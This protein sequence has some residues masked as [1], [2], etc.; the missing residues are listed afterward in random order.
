MTPDPRP[1]DVDAPAREVLPPEAPPSGAL[2]PGAVPPGA[3]AVG[4]AGQPLDAGALRHPLGAAAT[5]VQL[6]SAFC[7][8]CRATR[9]I[10][11]RVVA[12][13][14]GV[15]HV[16]VDVA[17]RADLA[18]R[19]AVTQTPTVVLLDGG[20]RPVARV[21]GVPSLAQARAAVAAVAG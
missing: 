9:R 18:E 8:P 3:A 11:E 12:T 6:S 4:A 2:P 1:H 15:V 5:F 16:E 13:T 19:F 17:D 7:A 21:T 14:E 10:L 20:G